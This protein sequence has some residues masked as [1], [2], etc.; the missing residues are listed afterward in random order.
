MSADTIYFFER[1]PSL[2]FRLF[3][4]IKIPGLGFTPATLLFGILSFYVSIF[5]VKNVLDIGIFSAAQSINPSDKRSK[6]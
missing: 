5:V 6:K 3:T 2:I 4:E 1:F